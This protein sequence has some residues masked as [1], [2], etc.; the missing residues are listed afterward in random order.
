[1]TR[2]LVVAAL[3]APT[4]LN[5]WA[6]SKPWDLRVADLG[7]SGDLEEAKL[8]RVERYDGGEPLAV[9]VCHPEQI[10]AAR[11]RWPK[12]KIVWV[13]HNA[14]HTTD[15]PAIDRWVALNTHIAMQAGSYADYDRCSVV[16]PAYHA[17]PTWR[18]APDEL[19][20]MQSRP[21]TPERPDPNRAADQAILD[22]VLAR[23][24]LRCCHRMFGQGQ[25]GGFLDESAKYRM[26]SRCSGYLSCLRP[27]A[28]F[29][30]AQH[31]MLA[32]GVPLIANEWLGAADGDHVLY[33]VTRAHINVALN[34]AG[35]C[36]DRDWARTIS[37]S[38]L[39]FIAKYRTRQIMDEG[40]ERLLEALA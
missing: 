6:S 19:W 20:T 23:G 30:L 21:S 38:G 16:T 31:E 39:A 25:P 2:P 18:W 27:W 28:G 36:R 22:E 5:I 1:M 12:A 26:M 10:A 33:G 40:I 32:A 11:E 24:N 8:L 4:L 7:G 9:M 13:L 14:R 3:Q 15:D 37:D 34:A 29:G 35:V 17:R